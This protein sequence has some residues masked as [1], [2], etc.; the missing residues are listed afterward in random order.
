MGVH[1]KVLQKMYDAIGKTFAGV[2]VIAISL[3]FPNS[4]SVLLLCEC[5]ACGKV[6]TSHS[7]RVL[8][9]QT[10]SC[11]CLMR[12]RPARTSP[13]ETGL[14]ELYRTYKKEAVY[15][16]LEFNLSFVSFQTFTS[17]VCFYCG[18]TPSMRRVGSR[19]SREDYG[20]YLYNGLDRVDNA[21]GYHE[22]NVV[23]CCKVCNSA[24]GIM[25]LDEFLMW[26]QK[27]YSYTYSVAKEPHNGS[28]TSIETR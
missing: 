23:A 11:G 18:S 22:H 17:S 4:G 19:G 6:C 14:N 20:A 5:L 1:T 24:K 25:T 21:I 9:S 27:V 12:V 3:E 15:R 10:R 8:D 2:R 28:T 26:I 7:S 16:S 13:G